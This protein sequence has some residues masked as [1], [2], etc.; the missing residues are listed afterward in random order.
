MLRIKTLFLG[1]GLPRPNCSSFSSSSADVVIAGGGM[2]GSAA[3]VALSKLA[4]MQ[5]RKIVLLEAGP[6]KK[7]VLTPEY[8]NRVSA[9]SPT[10]VGLLSKLGAWDIIQAARIGPVMKMRV[11][12]GCSRAGILFDSDGDSQ[13]PLSY[14]VENDLTVKALTD[15]LGDCGNLEVR[16][17]ARVKGY[18][19]PSKEE[20]ENRP[21]EEVVVELE[22]GEKIETSLLVGA[23][24]FRSLVRSSLGCDYVG[25][26]Y[27]QMGIVATLVI[28]EQEEPNMTAWQRFLPTGPVAVLPLCQ[29]KS[30][31]VWTVNKDM[32]R[33][34]VDM[35][36][37]TFIEKLN[38]ALVGKEAENSIV[39][40]VS[41]GFDLILNSFLPS[42]TGVEHSPPVVKGVFNRAAFPLGF[43]HS[44]RYVG[45]RAV[46]IG[47]AAHRVH[48]LAGQG[49]NLGFGDVDSLAE[50]VE[51]MVTEGGGLGHHEYLCQY[52]T[53]RQR[54]N[55]ATMVGVDCLQK[56]YCTDS[57]PLVLARSL[58]IM[59]TNAANPVKKI[60]MQHAG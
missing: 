14:L 33:D 27:N 45:P 20:T 23:D 57:T 44:T 46:L 5:N 58:G 8:S 31:L 42:K 16:Y 39:N 37:E 3:A 24:G 18:Q 36:K 4:C 12:D 56:L 11:W 48:P 34:M 49:V 59:A 55:L 26:E 13:K 60:I 41:E 30:S 52:E 1:Q 6:E 2:V 25:W 19:L 7:I 10:S 35:E 9:L 43:G 54:H 28:E 40:S 29:N 21:K 22:G 53:D 47:D 15:V 32:A 17:G 50:M 51:G 38:K